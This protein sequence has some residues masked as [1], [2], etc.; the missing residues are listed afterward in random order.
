MALLRPAFLLVLFVSAQCFSRW[1]DGGPSLADLF[2]RP[3][4]TGLLR[5][6]TAA[7]ASQGFE[8]QSEGRR[9]L[10]SRPA[11]EGHA[12]VGNWL[13]VRVDQARDIFMNDTFNTT[14]VLLEQELWRKEDAIR[15]HKATFKNLT[16]WCSKAIS[17]LEEPIAS[18]SQ[19][20]NETSSAQSIMSRIM[21]LNLEV[22]SF[23]QKIPEAQAALDQ[24][25]K[26]R[27]AEHDKYVQ[28]S[29]ANEMSSR[30]LSLA[31]DK[32][33]AKRNVTQDEELTG[34]DADSGQDPNMV[35]GVLTQ[36]QTHL[37]QLKA[38]MDSQE[39]ASATLAQSLQG[40][41]AAYIKTSSDQNIVDKETVAKL[42]TDLVQAQRN[43]DRSQASSKSLSSMKSATDKTCEAKKAAAE[44]IGGQLMVQ[45]RAI[46]DALLILSNG[47]WVPPQ[48]RYNETEDAGSDN[49]TL[50]PEAIDANR[51]IAQEM[52]GMANL[53]KFVAPSTTTP[54][55]NTLAQNGTTA[56][57][58]A[59][60][61]STVA[62]QVATTTVAAQVF[63]P[64]YQANSV[65]DQLAKTLI[66][67]AQGA[68]G[69]PVLAV[70]SKFLQTR[71]K[72]DGGKLPKMLAALVQTKRGTIK[73]AVTAVRHFM[74]VIQ[75][76]MLEDA[77]AQ[78]T[79]EKELQ[80]VQ[81]EVEAQELVAEQAN[82]N[83]NMYVQETQDINADSA[84]ETSTVANIQ[85]QLSDQ[86]NSYKS[87]VM[88]Y[89]NATARRSASIARVQMAKATIKDANAKYPDADDRGSQVLP[90]LDQLIMSIKREQS[91]ANADIM[92]KQK[93]NQDWNAQARKSL[94]DMQES[95]STKMVAVARTTSRQQAAERELTRAT[96]TLTNNQAEL[97]AQTLR[98]N[99]NGTNY[100]QLSLQRNQQLRDLT[101]II[102]ILQGESTDNAASDVQLLQASLETA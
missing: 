99:G 28:E 59:T 12:A 25:L 32:L 75:E 34:G 91:A 58:S 8:V 102:L 88:A 18:A 72:V 6:G 11:F 38:E 95:Q 54:T 79:C 61:T 52:G 45:K 46:R 4:P 5:R 66:T 70:P 40:Q 74:G 97:A 13:E 33:R 96:A 29:S 89:N 43:T 24:L 15:L 39:N 3:A 86:A 37:A 2:G 20:A 31:L 49:A 47:T 73:D 101:E 56:S 48:D 42:E 14:I 67:Q 57:T 71:V 41:K 77:A 94:D 93:A 92:L 26:V 84:D 30:Q 1:S 87:D 19:A 90:I 9:S 64:N 21:A 98:C 81:Q 23:R 27:Q 10:R 78:K 51:R 36:I 22:D 17:S 100:T 35:F 69:Q 80:V 55:T 68:Q 50:D 76:R 85:T 62:A 53:S 83:H 16:D 60:T 63:A 65:Q 7:V 82:A 44:K